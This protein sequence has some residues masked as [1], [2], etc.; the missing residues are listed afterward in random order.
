MNYVSFTVNIAKKG[1][2]RVQSTVF[3]D[4]GVLSL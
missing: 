2:V 4:L 1:L 3:C